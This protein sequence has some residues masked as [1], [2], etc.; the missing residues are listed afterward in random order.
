[1]KIISHRGNLNGRDP[2]KENDPS[3]IEIAYLQGFD[4]E[5]DVWFHC[6]EY[7][8]GHDKPEHSVPS[9]WLK[10]PWLW[11]H[12]KNIEAMERMLEDNIH[13]FWHEND[14]YT[15]TSKGVPWCYP[16]NY[17]KNGIVV[18]TDAALPSKSVLGICTDYP[19]TLR[20][21]LLQSHNNADRQD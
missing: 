2:S 7:M 1:M 5:V 4:V 6:G 15:L 21:L 18:L 14:R 13:Y 17:N 11:C 8:L 3:S 20:D 10:H 19:L 12:A 9:W 16:N